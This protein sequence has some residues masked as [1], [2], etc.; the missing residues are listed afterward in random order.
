MTYTARRYDEIV[1]DMLTTLTGG[2][3]GESV[4]VPPDAVPL[5]KLH[6]HP[7][8]R[9]SHAE[10]Q[11]WVTTL[12]T[13]GDKKVPHK[14]LKPYRFSDAEFELVSTTGNDSDKD[15]I[16]FREK[17]QKPA[18]GSTL[19]INYYPV[20]TDP[21]PLTDVSVGSV[22][23]TLLETVAFE[24]A[25]SYQQL[26]Q[27]YKS[28]FVETAEGD[29]LDR[30]V[31]LVGI[32]RL[33][34]GHPVAKLRF[35]RRPGTSGSVA[36]PA[37][38]PITDDKGNRYLTTADAL[39]EPG[40]STREV[41]AAGETSSTQEV[42][43]GALKYL[44]LAINGI[45]EVTNPDAARRLAAEETDKELRARSR[46]ALRGT[47]RGTVDAIRFGLL[48]IEGVKEVTV[49]EPDDEPG[50]IDVTVAYSDDSE[51]V[52]A[53]VAERLQKLRPAGIL[54]R[55][56]EA[57]KHA[58]TVTVTLTLAGASLP[59]AE[60]K[61]VTEGAAARVEETLTAIPPG[62]AVRN[63]QLVAAVLGD[64]RIVDAQ[65]ALSPEGNVPA[66]K[67]IDV[68]KVDV[69][70]P[71]FEE[72]ADAKAT[73]AKVSVSL[74]IHLVEAATEADAASAIDPAVTTY[75]STRAIDASLTVDGLLAAIRDE[76]R[77]VV[78]RAEVLV[79]VESAGTFRQLT[80]G[81]GSYTPA[82]NEKLEK[83]IIAITVREGTV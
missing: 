36:I 18:A 73:I 31:A 41:M 35:T 60:L 64:T 29:A 62:G 1:R 43:A 5:L 9:V 68:V 74:P 30:V 26:E 75:L 16:R 34:G 45:S 57:A 47:L 32:T 56:G 67:I 71:L 27:V 15:A 17:G 82:P 42:D 21:V 33:A 63:A 25:L 20:Q 22:V 69:A 38:T 72:S 81:V 59:A 78:V 44:E 77:Y 40:E 6:D 10:G 8:R 83:D 7:V 58:V 49:A 11:I 13:E 39:L 61:A 14:E 2:T 65:I 46:G 79:T 54:V 76:S 50:I 80:D 55:S 48:S 12:K 4:I 70:A 53:L 52:K 19:V 23:R 37:R 66:G 3:V 28:A 24:L 51:S